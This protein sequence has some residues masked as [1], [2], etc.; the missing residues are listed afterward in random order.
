MNWLRSLGGLP[1]VTDNTSWSYGDQ[2]HAQYMVK[3][4][5]I[6]HDED[7]ANV[8]Y[9]EEGDTAAGTSNVMA[10]SSTGYTDNGAIDLW[11]GGPFHGLGIID[12]ALSVTG[13]VSYRAEDGGYQM[14]ACLDVIRGL[15]SIPP[16]VTFPILWPANN[17]ILPYTRFNGGEWPEPLSSCPGFTLPS[18]PPIYLQIG[19]GS[20][21]PNVTAYSF[22]QGSTNLEICEFDETNYTNPNA[23]YQDLGRSVLNMRDAIV[24]MPRAPLTP[25][26]TYTVSITNSGTTYTWSFKVS[27]TQSLLISNPEIR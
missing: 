26:L 1:A 3:N 13:Y 27:G 20:Q 17:N 23:S 9:T 25:G 11:M 2:L 16:S 19:S 14:G 18:G 15:G 5:Y 8:W 4:D 21:I 6:G 10:P 22:N 12:P 24:I 7:P